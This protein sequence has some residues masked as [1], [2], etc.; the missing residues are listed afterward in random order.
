MGAVLSSILEVHHSITNMTLCIPITAEPPPRFAPQRFFALYPHEESLF[1]GQNNNSVR[2]YQIVSLNLT[3]RFL[4]FSTL[5]LNLLSFYKILSSL[6][7]FVKKMLH[8][9]S[10][11]G[12]SSRRSPVRAQNNGRSTDNVRPHWCF[13]RSNVRLAGHVDRTHLLVAFIV[14]LSKL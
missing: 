10:S 5:Q 14:I 3:R 2:C 7:F 11:T 6:L 8:S 12:H 9:Q 13:D 1:T 4:L